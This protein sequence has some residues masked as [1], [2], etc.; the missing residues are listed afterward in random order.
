MPAKPA[1]APSDRAP[2][3][4][5]SRAVHWWSSNRR[6]A[7]LNRR[8]VGAAGAHAKE[9][10]RVWLSAKRMPPPM[11]WLAKRVSTGLS[12]AKSADVAPPSADAAEPGLQKV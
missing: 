12:L 10:N 6:E 7:A 5:R 1:A 9:R 8:P 4:A 2:S 3:R 11:T